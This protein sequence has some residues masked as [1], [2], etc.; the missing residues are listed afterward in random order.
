MSALLKDDYLSVEDYLRYEQD[1]PVRH[2]YVHGELY[3]M[4]GGSDFHNRISGNLFKV[5]DDATA[6]GQ[7]E[8][9]F[10]DM[11]IRVSDT[12]YYYPDVVVAC[13]DPLTADRYT[14]KE[15]ALI[16]EVASPKTEAKD[17]REKLEAYQTIKSL[18]EYVI[19]SQDEVSIH[20]YRRIRNGT[21]QMETYTD[22][23]QEV[24]FKSVGLRLPV[25][26]IYRRVKFPLKTK[27]KRKPH[28]NA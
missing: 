24:E 22:M 3:A 12:V 26:Q 17:R 19:V 20:L 25:A 28:P 23:A 27:P 18:K 14:R 1:S 10:A 7:C 4:A 5:I 6:D 13:D 2:E 11:K 9:F 21:W 16:I 8:T 15:P